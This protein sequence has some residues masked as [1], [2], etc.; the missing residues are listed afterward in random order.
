MY[1]LRQSF[2]PA[3]NALRSALL[4]VLG[5]S[6]PAIP[7]P[8]SAGYQLADLG[9]D[10]SPKDIN[11]LGVVVGSRSTEQGASVAF[12]YTP[13]AGVEDLP[14]GTVAHSIND[15]GDIA[16]TT[17]SGAFLIS[18]NQV[19]EWD[20]YGAFGINESGSI[21]GNKEMRNPYRPTPLP[22]APAVYNGNNWE[23]MGIAL[24]YSRGTRKGV[25]ADL[26]V[27]WGINGQGYAVG[28]RSR[29]GL[30]GS[31]AIL[32]VPPYSQVK[33]AADVIYLPTPYGG[34]A[35]SIN[36][37]NMI[38]GTTG[39]SSTT[40]TFSHAFLYDYDAD[41][42]TDLG[43]LLNSDGEYGLRSSA[44]DINSFNQVVGS[45]WLVAQ[46]TSLYDP[47]QYHAFLWEDGVMTD[48]NTLPDSPSEWILTSAV[49]INDRGDIAG[50][51]LFDGDGDGQLETHGYLLTTAT[52]EPSP[53]T[54][55]PPVAVISSI[56]P[57]S[58]RAPLTGH[59]DA[60]G[61]YD[62]DGDPLTYTWDFGDGGLGMG[63]L[64]SHEYTEPGTYVP[65]L[66]V[67]DDANLS[68]SV[69]AEVNVRKG[70]GTQMIE[71]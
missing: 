17:L 67:T 47:S 8:V 61:S 52:I 39:N 59:F 18:G 68:D 66:T 1:H 2:G 46:N 45:S 53:Q 22:L 13:D 54:N 33:D 64:V 26:Y 11:N 9:V 27:L 29:Y 50:T 28:Q 7:L 41:V 57:A 40:G 25:Y 49:A 35:A 4:A 34:S 23:V 63:D 37:S 58:G 19:R 3:G 65:V 38:V 69:A 43:T 55:Q 62:A 24:T 20:G 15:A 30:T 71:R 56:D 10:V 16:G 12:R 31:S 32:V 14:V 60:T 42:L 70:H 44:S 51:G 5:L 36:E 48:L 21:S 6:A